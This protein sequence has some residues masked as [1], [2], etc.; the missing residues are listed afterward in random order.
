MI[1][2]QELAE[3]TA[4]I[5]QLYRAGLQQD[6]VLDREGLIP[7]AV[8]PVAPRPLRSWSEALDALQGLL[9]RI[10]A[11]ADTPQRE[12]WLTEMT[13]SLVSLTRM[14]SGEKI[15]FRDRLRDQLRVDPAPISDAILEGYRAELR[16][17]LDEMGYRSG[18]LTA[19][20]AA[21]ENATAVAPEDVI[22]RLGDI[23]RQAQ[24]RSWKMVF[25][26]GDDWIE[27]KAVYDRPYSAYCDYPGRSL[28]LNLEFSY[29]ESDLKHLATHEA[30]PGHLVH[31]ARREHLVARGEMPLEGAQVVT[32]SASSALFEG[33]AENGIELLDWIDGP[34]D[35][36]GIAIQ[37]IRSALR[38]NAAWMVFEDGLT[39]EEAAQATASGAFQTLKA[40]QRRLAFLSHEL[41]APFLFAYWAGDDAVQRFIRRS[42]DRDQNFVVHE[43]FD[44]MHTPTTLGAA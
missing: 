5:D 27:P 8:A 43:L 40:T 21:W 44:K 17:A 18:D 14:F 30:F 19:D 12:G 28:W 6:E 41:R 25:D 4:G 16:G 10:P 20:V 37:R 36:A 2:G 3:L 13:L 7:V 35:V 9:A 1:L 26:I 38:C 15:Q 42:A 11:E 33:I 39:I 32:N 24:I 29:T 23:Q 22:A 31:L 34:Q